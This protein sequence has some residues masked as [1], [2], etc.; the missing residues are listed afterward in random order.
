MARKKKTEKVEEVIE[1]KSVAKKKTKT[2]R[3]KKTKKPVDVVKVENEEAYRDPNSGAIIFTS[4]AEF[5]QAVRRKR[6]NVDNKESNKEIRNLK[7]QV[8][9]LASL[10][11]NLINKE[12]T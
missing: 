4:Q 3:K 1:E 11:N 7:K 5:Q 12:N 10:V 9:A 8:A 6:Q 2:T